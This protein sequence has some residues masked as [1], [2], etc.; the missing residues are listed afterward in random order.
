M[1]RVRGRRCPLTSVE[2]LPAPEAE[3]LPGAVPLL[4]GGRQL[5]GRDV[6]VDGDADQTHVNPPLLHVEL[7]G[8]RSR[9]PAAEG[10]SKRQYYYILW[11]SEEATSRTAARGEARAANSPSPP[12]LQAS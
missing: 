3:Y 9:I 5:R 2:D 10:E 8:G 11:T 4:E 6:Q 12:P 1:L 7:G